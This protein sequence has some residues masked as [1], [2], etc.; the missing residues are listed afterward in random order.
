MK[1]GPVFKRDDSDDFVTLECRDPSLPREAAEALPLHPL[2]CSDPCVQA[3]R[4]HLVDEDFDS[5]HTLSAYTQDLAQF[6]EHC[7][8][9]QRPPFDWGA[10]DRYSVRGFLVECQKGGAAPSTTRRKL[11]AIRT[12]Y[13][14]LLREGVVTRN[15]CASLRGP[16]MVRSLPDV[17][18][19][20]QVD[21]LLRAPLESLRN[22]A[23]KARAPKPVEAY[24]A[25]RDAALFEFLYSTG[26]RV[27]EAAAATMGD[28]DF[29]TGVVRLFGKGRKERLGVLGHPALSALKQARSFAA[30]LWKESMASSSPLFL[31]LHGGPLT[32]R[33][34]ERQMKHWLAVA[35]L[36]PKWTPHKLRHSFATHMLD[37][38]ADLRSVQEMLGHSSL[39]T[40]QIYTH[41][42]IEHLREIY[43]SAHPRA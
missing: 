8:H 7:F 40:T 24:A 17:L 33:S 11:A 9:G 3:F 5:S 38:G 31:N 27:A 26:A 37:A 39:S 19:R 29:K 18:T 13:A 6:A 35:G 20:E 4:R 15:P 41:V 43:E 16:K 12:F 36:P 32:T 21:K 28:V 22:E 34:M 2:G 14:F 25:W 23:G 1:R 10:L 30:Y 42:T